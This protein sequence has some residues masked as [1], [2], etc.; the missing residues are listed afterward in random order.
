LSRWCGAVGGHRTSRDLEALDLFFAEVKRGHARFGCGIFSAGEAQLH[1]QLRYARERI[2]GDA[3]PVDL[4]LTAS[5]RFQIF[6]FELA[7]HLEKLEV[8]A[9]LHV[10]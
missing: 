4:S 8:R 3:D 10:S 6:D 2:D 7:A 5:S 9:N 1:D